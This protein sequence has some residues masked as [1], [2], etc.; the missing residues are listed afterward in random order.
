MPTI[1]DEIVANT[2]KE[3]E[4]RKAQKSIKEL[5]A[6]PFFG[7]PFYALSEALEE[8][9][10][11]IIA[12]CK[13]RSPSK[14]WIFENANIPAIAAGYAQVGA[15]AVSI[16]TDEKYFGGSMEF[17]TAARPHLKCPILRK[18]FIVDEYQVIESK[19]I[20]ADVILL[21][22]ACLEPAQIKKFAKLA[23]SVGLEVL[24]EVH[25]KEELERSLNPEID[26]V[27]VNNRNLKTFEVNLET[28]LELLEFIPGDL[29][30]ISES[31]L[32]NPFDLIY[33]QEAGFDGFLIGEAFMATENPP[34]ALKQLISTL[35]AIA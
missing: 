25:D 34:A 22:A 2:K 9:P 29:P 15:A 35:R 23:H 32:Q 28:S 19:A 7:R 20:G 33:L 3:L 13:R 10:P 24:L 31:G 16:L 26:V 21:I 8:T 27:G 17:V 6:M 5:E 1:L 18:D 12:E 30:R 4:A 14:D 11:G